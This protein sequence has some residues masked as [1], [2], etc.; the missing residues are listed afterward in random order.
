MEEKI[1]H[2]EFIQNIITRNNSNSF[3]L[4]GWTVT[5]S[6]ALYALSVPIEEPYLVLITL[7]PIFL[8]WG[9]DAYYLS[10]ERCFVDLYNAVA[11]G[12]YSIPNS[13]ILKE[14]YVETPTTSEIGSISKFDMNFKKFEVWKDNSWIV[15]VKSKTLVWF[16]L[17]LTVITFAVMVVFNFKNHEIK[18]IDVNANLKSNGLELNIKSQPSTIIKNVSPG[19]SSTVG[20]GV[21]GS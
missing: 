18:T 15:V 6:A 19:K 21:K 7:A 14:N 13:K 8:F 17:P 16:Y 20:K 1:K 2:L 4:K 10:N 5:I 3:M 9:L 12:S 11:T